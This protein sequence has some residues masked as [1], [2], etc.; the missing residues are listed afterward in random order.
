M[1]TQPETVKIP[2]PSIRQFDKVIW[3]GEL[4]GPVSIVYPMI[5]DELQ[6][7]FMPGGSLVSITIPRQ[8]MVEILKRD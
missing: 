2:A 8:T 5:N 1:T 4:M 3:K 6:I 7:R